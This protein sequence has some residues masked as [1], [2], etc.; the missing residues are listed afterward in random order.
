MAGRPWTRTCLDAPKD[1]IVLKVGS[2]VSSETGSEDETEWPV[3]VAHLCPRV[4]R[5]FRPELET[6]V[7][8]EIRVCDARTTDTSL[9]AAY[10]DKDVGSEEGF[11]V[12]VEASTN[13]A[14]E[15]ERGEREI[16]SVR[17]VSSASALVGRKG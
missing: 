16:A 8:E 7:D 5:G 17:K 13:D 12:V 15:F 4:V 11:A 3:A 2:T 10:G 14:L 6:M 9:I 1:A